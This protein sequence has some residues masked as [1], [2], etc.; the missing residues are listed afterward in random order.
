MTIHNFVLTDSTRKLGCPV[1]SWI[2]RSLAT[3]TLSFM[4]DQNC[5]KNRNEMKQCGNTTKNGHHHVKG[6]ESLTSLTVGISDCSEVYPSLDSL[7]SCKSPLIF[8]ILGSNLLDG[9]GGQT[10]L[11]HY[12][13]GCCS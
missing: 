6:Y 4:E 5:Q 2:G 7:E 8:L 13:I 10:M 3:S 1:Q 9:G 12:D 11:I